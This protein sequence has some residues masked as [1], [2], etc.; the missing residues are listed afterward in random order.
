MLS[1]Y[2]LGH[3]AYANP[4]SEDS[5]RGQGTGSSR[6]TREALRRSHAA[7]F[8]C[9]TE[10]CGAYVAC[11]KAS[12]AARAEERDTYQP[13]DGCQNKTCSKYFQKGRFKGIHDNIAE[14]IRLG[15]AQGLKIHGIGLCI[16][17][18]TVFYCIV[19]IILYYVFSKQLYIVSQSVTVSTRF[20][21]FLFVLPKYNKPSG[22][23]PCL[24]CQQ[25][26]GPGLALTQQ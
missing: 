10:N 16:M 8:R 19:C 24:R 13:G 12:R 2:G 3:P 1:S 9:E 4:W 15:N 25:N 18:Y 21:W 5:A 17:Y 22:N 20:H 6:Y 23:R 14:Q 26:L 7:Y 11:E